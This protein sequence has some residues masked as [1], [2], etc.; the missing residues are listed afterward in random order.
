MQTPVI[1]TES[2]LPCP[3]CGGEVEIVRCEEFCC[4]A[5]P[6]I[7]TCQCGAE[8]NGEGDDLIKRWN[9]RITLDLL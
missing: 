5:K 6:R 8:L 7:I 1:E 2:L 4:G 9:K 3:F